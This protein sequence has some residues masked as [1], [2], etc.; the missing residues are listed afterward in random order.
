MKIKVN[1]RDIAKGKKW[2]QHSCPVARALKKSFN[3]KGDCVTVDEDNI[4]L[5][6]KTPAAIK[7]FIRRFDTEG[8]NAVKPSSFN[9]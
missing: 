2:S 1:S 3:V 6:L 8:K 5:E 9:L 7:A 4:T